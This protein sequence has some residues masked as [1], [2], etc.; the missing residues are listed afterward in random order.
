MSATLPNLHV[1]AQWQKGKSYSTSYRPIPLL[2]MVKIGSTLYNEDFSVIRD[3]HSSEIKIKDDGEHLIQLCLETVLEGYSVLI[4]CPAKAWCEK[5][6]L[7]IA[8]SFYS[9]GK[10]NSGY[11]E[12]I[13]QSLR[14]RLNEKDLNRIIEALRAS[15]AGL[16]SVLERSLSFGAAFHHAGK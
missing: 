14:N 7:N 11:P 16:D 3:L 6:S 10:N 1:L 9:I 12:N 5:V 8:S 15:P 13:V 4:F 2:Q